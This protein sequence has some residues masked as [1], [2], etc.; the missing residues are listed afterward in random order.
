M[1]F[2]LHA[3]STFYSNALTDVRIAREARF[4]GYEILETK[5]LRFLD[6]GYTADDLRAA[7]E[8]YQVRPVCINALKDIER[9]LPAERQL[10]LEEAERL[11]TAA[12]ALGFPTI[13]LLPRCGLQGRP[14]QEVLELTARN[15]ADIA[16][17][18][19]EHGVRFQL[20]PVAWSPVHSLAQA[21][22]V[23]A[24]AGRDN[25]GLVIDFWHLWARGETL[26]VE[27]TRLDSRLIYG[28]HFCDG[29]KPADPEKAWDEFALRSYLPGEGDVPISEW[30]AAV[31]ATGYDGSWSS[32][33]I[34]PRHWEWDLAEI[35]RQTR[36]L[37]EKYVHP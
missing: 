16:D 10:L 28:I 1:I 7:F 33:L 32:E 37:M 20:E 6:Q 19:R 24:A 23:V 34:S 13:Q 21:L 9:V 31:K 29:K 22:E 18:G 12:E 25:V 35:A 36:G 15:V 17:I 27:V 8:Q 14:W 11:C 3:I 30:V 4:E 5:L 2:T 26:P